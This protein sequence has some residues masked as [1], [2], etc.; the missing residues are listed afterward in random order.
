MKNLPPEVKPYRRTPEFTESTI[1]AGLLKGHTTK[2]GVW[3]MIH[4]LEGGIGGRNHCRTGDV[5]RRQSV[6]LG[7][8]RSM[9]ACRRAGATARNSDL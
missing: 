3:A 2:P 4:V 6:R 7:A 5:L 8:V 1:P 9:N